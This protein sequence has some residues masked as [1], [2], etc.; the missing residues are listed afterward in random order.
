[1]ARLLVVLF[2]L[3]VVG[4]AVAI[5]YFLLDDSPS[6]LGSAVGQMDP[7]A[8]VDPGDASKVTVNIPPGSTANDI[9]A[10]LQQLGLVRSSLYFRYAAD[11]AGVGGNLAAGDYELS[12]SMS[13]PEII[14]VL[15]KGEVKRG[16][17]ATIP[18]GW[19][20]EQI[21]DRLQATGFAS[22]ADFLQA[23]AS[24]QSVPGFDTLPPPPPQ[25]LEGFLFPDT[26]EVPQPVSGSRATELMLRM[27]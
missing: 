17:V 16:L 22:R 21:A 14:Q 2:A 10:E 9:G 23:L 27:F 26:Y 8:P 7:A 1:M 25:R 13:T 20:A 11:Q 3:I 6:V 18:E 15:A 24:P 4:A 5:G 19:R 12:K